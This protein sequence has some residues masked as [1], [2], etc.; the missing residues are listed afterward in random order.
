MSGLKGYDASEMDLDTR[1]VD[2]MHFCN[3]VIETF[4]S[5]SKDYN[6]PGPC[7]PLEIPDVLR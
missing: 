7:I 4:C 6:F 3:P 2:E 5:L 1:F